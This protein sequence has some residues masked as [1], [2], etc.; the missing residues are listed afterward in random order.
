M[1]I[2]LNPIRIL[3]LSEDEHRGAPYEM[4]IGEPHR[5]TSYKYQEAQ[6][7]LYIEVDGKDYNVYDPDFEEFITLFHHLRK[8]TIKDRVKR[9][10]RQF[11][12]SGKRPIKK[13]SPRKINHTP[14][15]YKRSKLN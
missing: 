1:K 8:E 3:I 7:R 6:N 5:I 9:F 10:M 11:H 15:I 2:Y 13:E 14:N 12:S 4:Y